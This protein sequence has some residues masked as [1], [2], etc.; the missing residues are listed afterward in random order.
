MKFAS[1]KLLLAFLL[2]AG[3]ISYLALLVSKT[4]RGIDGKPLRLSQPQ[5]LISTLDLIGSFDA[6]NQ[7]RVQEVLYST[8]ADKTPKVGDFLTLANFKP[9]DFDRK[10]FKNWL[11]PLRTSQD[12]KTFEIVAVPQ[13]PGFQGNFSRL[14]SARIY[15]ALEGALLQYKK[16]SKG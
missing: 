2:F 12:G 1:F 11:I 10:D 3:W 16:F 13:S 6:N 14:D 8:L 15:P 5:F 7:L 4:T 9:G